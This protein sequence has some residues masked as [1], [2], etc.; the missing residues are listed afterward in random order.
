MQVHFERLVEALTEH[1]RPDPRVA[2]AACLGAGA[3]DRTRT[4]S[5]F[6]AAA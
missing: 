4:E 3:R 6:D 5:G 2:D 1:D